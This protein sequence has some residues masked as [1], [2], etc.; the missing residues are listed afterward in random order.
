MDFTTILTFI[1]CICFIL[2]I[3]KIFIVPL[4]VILKLAINSILGGFLIFLINLCG[5]TFNFHIGLN[6]FTAIFVGILGIPRCSYFNTY[7]T[8]T[9]LARFL[10]LSTSRFLSFAT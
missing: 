1:A 8:V 4:K 9:D 2:I 7:S 6:L 10:G 5:Q 3:G